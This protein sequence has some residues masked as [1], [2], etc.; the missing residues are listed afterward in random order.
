M[1]V[2]ALIIAIEEYPNAKGLA[3]KLLGTLKAGLEF[4][5][6]LGSKLKAEG[7]E[8]DA[9]ILFCSSP[10]QP[11]GR[12]ATQATVLSSVLE[13]RKTGIRATDELFVFFSGHGF[14][15]SDRPGQRAHII[16]T[17]GFVDPSLSSLHCLN[18]DEI[19]DVLRFLGPGR[20]YYFVD[21][22][23][24]LLD[25]TKA[26]VGGT[27]PVISERA[28]EATTYLLQSTVAG[29]GAL[30]NGLFSR[31]L[32]AGLH[33]DGKAK[34]WDPQYD[35]RML[36]RY[37]SLRLYLKAQLGAVQPITSTVMGECGESEGVLA[38]IRPIP[39]VECTIAVEDFTA[40]GNLSVVIQ[41]RRGASQSLKF[42]SNPLTVQLY[43]DNYT[44]SIASQIGPVATGQVSVDVYDN[45]TVRLKKGLALKSTYQG[46]P[47]EPILIPE[48]ESAEFGLEIAIAP[49]G[50][51]RLR[52]LATGDE[53]EVLE[54]QVLKLRSG[55]YTAR[56]HD[57]NSR[58]ISEESLYVSGD[59]APLRPSN[60][61]MAIAN[62]LP[63]GPDGIYFS[64]A[65]GGPVAD[66]DLNLWLAIVGGGRILRSPTNYR[67]IASFPLFDFTREEPGASPV[68]VLAAFEDLEVGLQVS[69]SDNPQAHWH[70][71]TAFPDLYHAGIREWYAPTHPGLKLV[72][73]RI[74]RR[75]PIRSPA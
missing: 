22:C 69:V 75:P 20:H 61:R 74:V 63:G 8:A 53:E 48:I 51:V 26:A 36:V 46:K 72:S 37:D 33:G 18:L 28:E 64:E 47:S 43:P 24:N 10:A 59:A 39:T 14:S 9:Q 55:Q 62:L 71:S 5:E 19:I 23:R 56:M 32:L 12:D 68:Y 65:L 2:R 35:D 13:L 17:S 58:L 7:K 60:P 45:Q 16:L 4:R 1:A 34:L 30:V 57:S 31:K 27:I 6:W 41:G 70:D 54:S 25:A 49:N 15:F 42:T 73:F 3:S 29:A 38:Q 44:F 40:S 11:D 50:S 21:A 52:N 66:T 67:K